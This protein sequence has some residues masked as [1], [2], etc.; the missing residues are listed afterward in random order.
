MSDVIARLQVGTRVVSRGTLLK[1]V[2]GELTGIDRST[3]W[4]YEIT[5]D[6]GSKQWFSQVVFLGKD[7]RWNLEVIEEG[8]FDEG[9]ELA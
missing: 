4:A 3:P 7:G 2:E 9:F 6:N 5:F 8:T 1:D